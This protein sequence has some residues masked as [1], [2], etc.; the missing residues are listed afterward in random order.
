VS[1]YLVK[2]E[3]DEARLL[4]ELAKARAAWEADEARRAAERSERLREAVLGRRFPDAPGSVYGVVLLQADRPFASVPSGVQPADLADAAGFV[5]GHSP[6]ACSGWERIG[7]FAPGDGR[8]AVLYGRKH[9]S[10]PP[11]RESFRG[12]AAAVRSLLAERVGTGVSCFY[13]VHEGGAAGLQGALEKAAEAA[14]HAVFCGRNALEDADGLPLPAPE[15]RASAGSR[16]IRLDELASGLGGGHPGKVESAVKE[17]FGRL[18]TPAWDLPGL[19]ET[20][21]ILTRLYNDRRAAA[22]QP[23]ENPLAAC[24]DGVYRI[25]EIERIFAAAFR[26]AAA[27]EASRLSGKMLKAIRYI[28][29]HYPEDLRIEDVALAVGISASYLHQLFKRELGRKSGFSRRSAFC[30]KKKRRCRMSAAGSAIG[31]RSI[32]A[33]CSSA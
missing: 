24:P 30:C 29:D 6:A 3:L 16:G 21:H 2:Y 8:L 22:G 10:A 20:V 15:R 11:A 32:S 14:R 9:R 25:D 13:V 31:R 23:E 33:R 28:H 5:E 7:A 18:T 17:L 27:G 19:Y 4:E 12:L 26:N 1:G